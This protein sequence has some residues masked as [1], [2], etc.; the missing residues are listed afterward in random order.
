MEEYLSLE[1][2]FVILSVIFVIALPGI[3]IKIARR[4]K[5][6][7]MISMAVVCLIIVSV[8]VVFTVSYNARYS[9]EG[10][11][12][13][14]GRITDI[15]SNHSFTVNSTKGTYKS[16][17]VG[18]VKVVIDKNTKVFD[19]NFFKNIKTVNTNDFVTVVCSDEE[20][21]D[22]VVHAVKIIRNH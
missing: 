6:G 1:F 10:K 7:F 15:T 18:N 4:S 11:N 12:Y 21:T 5:V 16:G 9:L 17:T 20:I 19:E 14:F 2:L 8:V 13:I 22:G 3:L